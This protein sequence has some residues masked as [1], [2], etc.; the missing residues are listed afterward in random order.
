MRLPGIALLSI[1]VLSSLSCGGDATGPGSNKPSLTVSVKPLGTATPIVN[2][3]EGTPKINCSWTLEASATG[4]GAATWEAA[5]MRFYLGADRG[6]AVD[7]QAFS[8]ADVQYAW[9]TLITPATPEQSIWSAWATAPFEVEI[10]FHF[11]GE[12]GTVVSPAKVRMPCGPPPGSAGVAPAITNFTVTP[13]SGGLDARLPLRVD[14]SASSPN[15]LWTTTVEVSGPFTYRSVIAEDGATAVQRGVNVAVPAAAQLGVP[16]VVKVSAT[17]PGLR[18]A[19]RTLATKAVVIDTTPPTMTEA[20]YNAP[21]TGPAGQWAVGDRLPIQL[22]ARDNGTLSWLVWEVGSPAIARDSVKIPD[23]TREQLLSANP[24][25]QPEWVGD[26]EVSVYVRD[27]AGLKSTVVTT[28]P[29]QVRFY[30]LVTHPTSATATVPGGSGVMDQVYDAK[31][32]ALYLS[33]PDAHRVARIDVA[34]MTVAGSVAFQSTVGGLDLTPGGDS[35]VVALGQARALAL[36]NPDRIT[37]APVMVPLSVLDTAGSAFPSQTPEP[38]WVRVAANGRV[39][40]SLSARTKGGDDVLTVDLATGAQRIRADARTSSPYPLQ[41]LGGAPDRSF[42]VMIG[43]D[44]SRLYQS[45][46][47]SF[48]P[49]DGHGGLAGNRRTFNMDAA[50]DRFAA[51]NGAYDLSFNQLAT[52]G[53]INTQLPTAAISADGT[54]LYLGALQAVSV[55]RIADGKMLERFNVPVSA[56]RIV[57]APSGAWLVAIDGGG[58]AVRVDLAPTPP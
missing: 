14:Y 17:D 38:S 53:P 10:E 42:I 22:W 34:T 43:S 50:G 19:S 18:T 56:D 44:C 11:I 13:D 30:P 5:V 52:S 7:S 55:L 16:I 27:G 20:S 28:A 3:P 41:T 26:Q 23:G 39:L 1:V 25:V 31:R 54:L 58:S 4:T 49:C 29:G 47:D 36:L 37:D 32:G 15:G 48:T 6:V 35:L 51:G 40:I 33:M 57:V 2:A 9:G 8:P 46:S 45:S 12:E 21:Y 24:V